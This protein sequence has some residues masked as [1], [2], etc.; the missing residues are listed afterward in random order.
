MIVAL[1]CVLAFVFLTFFANRI[2]V[3]LIGEILLGFPWGV[4]QTMTT[5]YASEVC[6]VVLRAYLTT[7]VFPLIYFRYQP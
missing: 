1:G 4:F 6:P 5:A 3:L 7:Y 2:E